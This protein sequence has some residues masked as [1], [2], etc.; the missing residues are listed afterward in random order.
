MV[1]TK[2]IKVFGSPIAGKGTFAVEDI[3]KG[4]LVYWEDSELNK[5]CP[6][7]LATLDEMYSWSDDK[8]EKFYNF[9]YQVSDDPETWIGLHENVD[10]PSEITDELYMNHRFFIFDKKKTF[11][12]KINHFVSQNFQSCDPNCWWMP[13]K[14]MIATRHIAKGEEVCYDYATSESDKV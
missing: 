8:R 7:K 9:A 10:Y 11:F 1:M 12:D 5:K 2:K 14:T 4:E 13:D 6:K 3:E